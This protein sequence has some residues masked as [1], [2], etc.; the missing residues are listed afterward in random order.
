M[1]EFVSAAKMDEIE[2]GSGKSVSVRGVKIAVF[3]VNG[4]YFA[5]QDT[6]PHRGGPLGEGT[7]D[8]SAVSCPWH[9][10]EFDL[11][12]G[13]CVTMAGEQVKTYKVRAENGGVY[14]AM[15]T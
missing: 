2:P 6:C 15:E 8:E 1:P 7:A 14:V 10:W 3:N 11:A 9:G 4:Q 13:Q 5:L 12:T